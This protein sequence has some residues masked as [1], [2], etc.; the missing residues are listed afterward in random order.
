MARGETQYGT[1][2]IVC[3]L[4][5]SMDGHLGDVS[6]LTTNSDGSLVFSG[7]RD[8]SIRVWD[9]KSHKCIREVKDQNNLLSARRREVRRRSLHKGDVTNLF[10]LNNDQFLLSMSFDGTMHLY[11]LGD[12]AMDSKSD[13]DLSMVGESSPSHADLHGG[14]AERHHGDGG[15]AQGGQRRA[16]R[17][18]PHLP[19]TFSAR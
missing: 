1:K 10:V 2:G 16:G 15:G 18:R 9:V 6:T 13:G 7:A 8:N 12:M 14:A 4:V 11:K 19:G 17:Q 3:A 5:G